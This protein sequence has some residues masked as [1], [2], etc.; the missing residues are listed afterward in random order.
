MD[1]WVN[2]LWELHR[3]TMSGRNPAR[4]G[5]DNRG[6]QGQTQGWG[7]HGGHGRGRLRGTPGRSTSS[8]KLEVKFHPHGIGREAQAVTYDTV[9]EAIVQHMQRSYKH[10]QDIAMSLRELKVKNLKTLMPVRWKSTERDA[11]VSANEQTCMDIVYQAELE[12][13]LDQKE[14][15]NRI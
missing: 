8:K 5:R 3:T 15:W 1:Y 9:K 14:S 11:S 10:R 12:R 6:R 2:K 4:S 13:Y 7:F